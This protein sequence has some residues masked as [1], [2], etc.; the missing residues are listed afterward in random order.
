MVELNRLGLLWTEHDR[1]I[2]G[3]LRKKLEYTLRNAGT[4]VLANRVRILSQ[5]RRNALN[6]TFRASKLRGTHIRLRLND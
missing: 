4:V 3:E 2:Q 1:Q 5:W 6:F